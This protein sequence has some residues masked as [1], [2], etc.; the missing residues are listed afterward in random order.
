VSETT[1]TE[2]GERSLPL[3]ESAR[4]AL[5]AL[6][7]RSRFTRDQDF[8]FA[9]AVGTPLNARN[10]ERREFKRALKQAGMKGAFRFHELRHYAVSTLIA[11]RAD[12]KLLQA[13]AGH[14]SATV[15]LTP[16]DI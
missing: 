5:A 10:F 13:I 12:I 2:A 9:T 7:L 6:K 4:K 16:T 1:K 3:F 15:T 14:A 8:V 11:Q